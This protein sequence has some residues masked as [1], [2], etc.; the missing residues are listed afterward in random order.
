[1]AALK[2]TTNDLIGSW[3]YYLRL[4]YQ[5]DY[6]EKRDRIIWGL[7]CFLILGRLNPIS[8]NHRS[9]IFTDGLRR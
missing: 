4:L 1:M 3:N 8:W 9:A 7:F 6:L 5:K 2:T